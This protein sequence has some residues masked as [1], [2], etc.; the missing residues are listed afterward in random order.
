[1]TAYTPPVVI[2]PDNTAHVLTR[3]SLS[4]DADLR[5]TEQWLQKALFANPQC[6]PVREIDPSMSTLIPVCMEIETGAGPADILYVTPAGLLVLVETKLW[7]SPEARRQVVGQVLDY[8]KQL[9]AWTYET[10][11]ERAAIAA[12]TSTGHL[13]RCLRA[14]HPDA[15]E[16]AFV[17]GLTRNLQAAELLLLI[18]GDGIRTGAESLV[19]FLERFGHLKFGLGLIEVAAFRLPDGG[20]LLQPRILARTEILRRTMLIGQSGPVQFEEA[21]EQDDKAT[22]S[23]LQLQRDWHRSF[24]TEFLAALRRL[25]PALADTEPAKSTNQFFSMPP[26]GGNAWIS[27]FIAQGSGSAGVYL[28]FAKSFGRA[29]EMA[30]RFEDDRQA[31]ERELGAELLISSSGQKAVVGVPKK[32]FDDLN[33][34]ERGVVIDY[35]ADKTRK[36]IAAF[37]PRLEAVLQEER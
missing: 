3:I 22:T 7:R 23:D 16:A 26:Y 8:A 13:L 1:M 36:M 6:L 17:D 15:D 30:Q 27:A 18:V 4:A 29:G 24:W 21:A 37:K 9:T 28:T 5:I 32:F 14:S 20:M 12:K 34:P 11:D 2:R 31:I 10:L 35:L 19:A 33:G 25:D